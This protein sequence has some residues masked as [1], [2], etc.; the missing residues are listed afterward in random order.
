MFWI[1]ILPV[2]MLFM[3]NENVSAGKNSRNNESG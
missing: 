3:K 1:V 2:P